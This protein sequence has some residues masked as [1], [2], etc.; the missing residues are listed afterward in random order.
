[1]EIFNVWVRLFAKCNIEPMVD[2]NGKPVYPDIETL[3]NGGI[4]TRPN[5][6]T[7]RVV[8]RANALI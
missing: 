4:V 6:P 5:N 2:S 7:M 8:E 3:V 1:M